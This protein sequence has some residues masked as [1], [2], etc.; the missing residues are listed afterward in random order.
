MKNAPRSQRELIHE[1]C[2]SWYGS[3]INDLQRLAQ[4]SERD[5]TPG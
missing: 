4:T 2:E 1:R 5:G 3:R